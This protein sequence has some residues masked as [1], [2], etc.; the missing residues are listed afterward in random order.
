MTRMSPAYPVLLATAAVM[1]AAGC[2]ELGLGP[3]PR[4]AAVSEDSLRGAA[5]Y[6]PQRPEIEASSSVS[7]QASRQGRVAVVLEDTDALLAEVAA[8]HL[9]VVGQGV[10]APNLAVGYDLDADVLL[11]MDGTNSVIRQPLSMWRTGWRASARWAV[12]VMPPGELPASVDK[13]AYLSAAARLRQSAS[14]WEAV[15]AYDAGVARWPEDADAFSGLA[16]SLYDLG[17]VQ[18]AAAAFTAALSVSRDPGQ[19][20]RIA[21]LAA[22]MGALPLAAARAALPEVAPH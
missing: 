10:H 13:K 5:S 8:G 22:S 18:G 16:R 1:W 3:L 7:T 4:Q 21:R 9:V 19:R 12:A 15:L 17:D 6:L 14:P 2:A 20:E 11:V